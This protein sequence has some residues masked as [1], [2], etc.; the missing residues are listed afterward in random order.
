VIGSAYQARMLLTSDGRLLTGLVVEDSPQ[1]VV[2]KLQGGKLETIP[3]EDIQQMRTSELS[4]MPEG[5]EKQL[6]PQE[7][8]DLFA[9]LLLEKPLPPPAEGGGQP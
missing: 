2:L 6:S 8:A 9:F 5:L 3:R 7:T 4:L 1:R